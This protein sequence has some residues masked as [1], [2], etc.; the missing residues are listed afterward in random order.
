MSHLSPQFVEEMNQALLARKA[1]LEADLKGIQPHTELGNDYD[2]DA[3]EVQLDEVNRDLISRITADLA[4][5]EVALGRVADGTY[6]V[7]AEGKEIS[8][9]RLRAIPWA[10]KAL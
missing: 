3:T 7:D 9:D 6:G 2:S 10:D 5:I 8:E 4:K 1:E